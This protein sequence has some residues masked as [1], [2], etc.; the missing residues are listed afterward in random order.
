MHTTPGGDEPL[1]R[2]LRGEAARAAPPLREDGAWAELA[3][4]AA[5]EGLAGLVIE[6]LA[7][8]GEQ[9]PD[10]ASRVL[11]G[12][13][14]R[15]E[16]DNRR[17]GRHILR[18]AEALAAARVPLML[19]KGAALQQ[20]V[21]GR[22]ELR[23]M[24]DVD[25]LV[26]ESDAARAGEVLERIGYARTQFFRDR[27]FFPRFYYETHYQC[28]EKSPCL[29]DLH[30]RPWRPMRYAR[31]VPA[32]AL[33][34][35]AKTVRIG[36]AEAYV[37][38]DD[39]LLIHLAVHAAVHGCG[40][41]LWLADIARVMRERSRRIDWHRTVETAI[42]WRVALP[43]RRALEAV[44]RTCGAGAPEHVMAALRR[45]TTSWRDR[46]ALWH[47]PR[48]AAHPLR[49]VLVNVLT[50]PGARYRLA[51]AK[52]LVRPERDRRVPITSATAVDGPE[53]AA[54]PSGA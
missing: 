22:A 31:T 32:D 10:E 13:A 29:I 4:R 5:R 27:S 41:L 23:P 50:T 53:I 48:D 33:W 39:H 52:A 1:I 28:G 18:V 3:R 45:A 47:A 7:K 37:P 17:L 51:Y 20:L 21:Y 11:S 30:V 40:R 35:R 12:A 26:R 54:I 25:L 6:A 43:M 16:V 2:V 36:N 19:L 8:A 9:A 46:L 42:R 24:S 14:R 49:H 15:T 38:C 34:A 44:E